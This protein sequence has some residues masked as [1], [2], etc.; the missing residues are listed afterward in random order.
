MTREQK[1][2][3]AKAKIDRAIRA[4]R[5]AIKALEA[6]E[7]LDGHK[8]GIDSDGNYLPSA[9]VLGAVVLL[10]DARPF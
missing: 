9:D 2:E 6:I 8:G 3:I 1:T 4:C 10:S 7:R 5:I